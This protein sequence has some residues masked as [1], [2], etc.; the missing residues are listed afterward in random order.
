[1]AFN[2]KVLLNRLAGQLMRLG[3]KWLAKK[4]AKVVEDK[5]EKLGRFVCRLAKKRRERVLANL[6]IAFPEMSEAERVDLCRRTFEHFGRST[7]DF[8]VSLNRTN[9]EIAE[10]LEVVGMEH[11]E[12]ALAK[13]KGV[14]ILSAH[15]GHWERSSRHLSDLGYPLSVVARDAN[16]GDVNQM[17]N[18]VRSGPGTN[19]IA[20]GDAARGVLKALRANELVAILADQNSDEIFIPFFGKPAGTV[21]GPGV[22][23]ERSGCTVL[24]GLCIHVGDCRYRFEC[25]GPL[26]PLPGSTK[27]EGLMLAYHAWLESQ[28]RLYPE[29]YLWLHD[30]WRSAR[31][32]GLL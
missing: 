1:V 4:P 19:V 3:Q 30:R 5:G 8:L 13:G 27:G 16:Q 32:R 2:K 29:Q 7:T 14:L 24:T 22:L 15:I 17:V 6:A 9:E 11:F 31:K 25:F 12:A 10:S 21:L 28:I 20:R 18:S 23:A 26:E